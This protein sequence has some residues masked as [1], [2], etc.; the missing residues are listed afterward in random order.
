MDA[1]PD[2]K[3]RG[4]RSSDGQRRCALHERGDPEWRRRSV[5][6]EAGIGSTDRIERRSDGAAMWRS[7]IADVIRWREGKGRGYGSIN[8]VVLRRHAWAESMVAVL[9]AAARTKGGG[10]R[11][12]G[13]RPRAARGGQEGPRKVVAS[14]SREGEPTAER[15]RWVNRVARRGTR[16][17]AG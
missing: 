10:A 9:L 5:E 12:E 6:E 7:R 16:K 11:A 3:E 14:G 2:R 17:K 4:R 13:G 15:V 1:T 8:R